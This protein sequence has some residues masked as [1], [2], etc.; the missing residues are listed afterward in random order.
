MIEINWK[1]IVQFNDT[2]VKGIGIITKFNNDKE[3]GVMIKIIEAI[4]NSNGK[5]IRS[6]QTFPCL[7]EDIIRVVEPY[8]YESTM[9]IEDDDLIAEL[10]ASEEA[11][12]ETI[13]IFE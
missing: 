6:G 5:K 7:Q 3:N 11:R 9:I 1:D 4:R 2:V 8:I 13:G 10:F 12:E